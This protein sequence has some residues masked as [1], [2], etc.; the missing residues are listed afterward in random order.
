VKTLSRVSFE[1]QDPRLLEAARKVTKAVPKAA[2][3]GGFV[4]DAL[5]GIKSKDADLETYG[6]TAEELEKILNKL[7]KGKV[8]TVGRS[9][10]I[11]KV[12]LG[13]GLDLDVA[14]PRTESKTGPGHKGFV[15]EGDPELDPKEAAR[16]RDFTINA[17]AA[18]PKT[19][20][21]FDPFNGREDLEK[22]LLRIVD[23]TTFVDDP[24]RVYRGIQFAA[25]FDLK[26]DGATLELMRLMVSRG[27]LDE[28]SKERVTD[29]LKKLFLKA[30]RPSVGFELMRTLGLIRRSYPEL[31]ALIDT[32]QE[33]EWHPEGDVWIHTMMVIDQAARI[34]KRKTQN[35]KSD[36]TSYVLHFTEEEQL[37]ILVGALCHDLGK[38]STT[39][40][41][42]KGG[43]PRIRSMGHE[44]AGEKPAE[45]LLN[46]WSF[47]TSVKFAA[48][49]C[50]KEHLKPGMLAR[51]FA[52]GTLTEEHYVNAIRKLIKRIQPLNWRVY[53]AVSEAD[54]RGRAFP[55]IDIGPYPPG[56]IFRQTVLEHQLDEEG[57]KPLLS[58]R[59]LLPFGVKPGPELGK[60]LAEVEQQRDE[61]KIR[62]RKQA[63]EYVAKLL[64]RL[65]NPFAK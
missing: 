52:T 65:P 37:Q 56:L 11:Y 13:D 43:I 54:A 57:I 50:A 61:N 22:H 25:R 5:L 39:H 41:G 49:M 9:F 44:E 7:F 8:E 1:G 64:K 26:I 48:M 55:G 28:L 53:L 62:T 51:Q 59:D 2:L 3:V 24:L 32:P 60:I 63:L 45:D 34:A 23:A 36:L 20:E 6:V 18:D 46:R 40:M 16:R 21:L 42:E 10:G 47:S 12:S 14:I 30:P 27:D 58:G 15:V 19:G 17:M 4:R 29:E 35:A 38:P 31:H 33:P